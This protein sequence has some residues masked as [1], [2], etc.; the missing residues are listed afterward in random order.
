MEHPLGKIFIQFSLPLFGLAAKS[1]PSTSVGGAVAVNRIKTRRNRIRTHP[2]L[3]IGWHLYRSY[4]F[5]R[6]LRPAIYK[7]LWL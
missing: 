7:F 3:P 2:D 6:L 5:D 4:T 1:M